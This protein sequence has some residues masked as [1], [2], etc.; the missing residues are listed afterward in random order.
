MK[1]PWLYCGNI[2]GKCEHKQKD[3]RC[4]QSEQLMNGVGEMCNDAVVV[5]NA[6]MGFLIKYLYCVRNRTPRVIT[7]TARPINNYPNQL[8]CTKIDEMCPHQTPGGK[9]K[10]I[11]NLPCERDCEHAMLINEEVELAT[12]LIQFLHRDL[13]KQK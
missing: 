6:D 7:T 9:C 3:G 13:E 11:E 2:T 8:Y 12:R 1:Y 5:T 4:A 10:L